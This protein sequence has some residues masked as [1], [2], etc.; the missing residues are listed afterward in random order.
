[1]ATATGSRAGSALGLDKPTTAVDT[2]ILLEDT[3]G[4]RPESMAGRGSPSERPTGGDAGSPSAASTPRSGESRA[5]RLAKLRQERSAQRISTA[6]KGAVEREEGAGLAQRAAQA[7]VLCTL[8]AEVTQTNEVI[9]GL[10]QQI[11]QRDQDMQELGAHT[12]SMQAQLAELLGQLDERSERL[13]GWSETSE[14]DVRDSM[15]HMQL[16]Q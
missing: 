10:Q 9:H 13:S 11:R 15:S 4:V 3:H 7:E 14:S 2:R 1:M 8:R 16:G 12:A 6:L 5:A